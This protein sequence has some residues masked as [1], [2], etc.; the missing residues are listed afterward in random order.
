M[1]PYKL[2]EDM[3][4]KYQ[5]EYIVEGEEVPKEQICRREADVIKAQDRVNI[6]EDQW[7]ITEL[8][9][10]TAKLANG[11]DANLLNA[12]GDGSFFIVKGEA[13]V[14]EEFKNKCK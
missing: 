14:D 8:R 11:K 10:V 7:A 13:H 12:V 6:H 5:K 3:K 4:E 9:N 2:S 1:A